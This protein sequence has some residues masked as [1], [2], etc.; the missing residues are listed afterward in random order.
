[1]YSALINYIILLKPNPALASPRVM[2]MVMVMVRVR[3]RVRVRVSVRVR[4]RARAKPALASP[5]PHSSAPVKGSSGLK[6]LKPVQ[7]PVDHVQVQP[8]KAIPA[9]AK[10][11]QHVACHDVA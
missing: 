7:A 1:M 3:V 8:L 9:P 5:S 4:A 11:T 2:V 6:Q 10:E